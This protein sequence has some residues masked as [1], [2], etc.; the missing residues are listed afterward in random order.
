MLKRFHRAPSETWYNDP[1]AQ[2][3]RR[4]RE[5]RRRDTIINIILVLIITAAVTFLHFTK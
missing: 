1:I 3:A 5:Q 2:E 4:R